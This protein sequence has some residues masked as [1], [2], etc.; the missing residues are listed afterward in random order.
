MKRL[1]AVLA[2]VGLVGMAAFGQDANAPQ[3]DNGF[4][5]N[6]LQNKLSAPGRQIN[7]SGVSGALSSQAKI[8]KIT[9]SDAQGPWFEIDNAEIDWNRLALLR[10]RVDVNRLHAEKIAWLRRPVMPPP[11]R[12]LPK[13]EAQPF[14]LP[15]LPVSINLR[16]LALDQVVFDEA[17]FGQQAALQVSG[18]LSLAGGALDST[19]AVKRLD[20]PGGELKLEASFSNDTRQLGIDIELQEPQGGV[21]ATLLNI[22]GKPAIDLRVQGSG[23]LDNV[24]VNFSL[25]AA[26]DRIAEGVVALRSTDAGLGF[27]VNFNGGLSPLIPQ[28]FRDFFAGQSTVK[29]TGVK[30]NEGGLRID[31]LKVA[32][33]ALNLTGGL[34]TGADNFLRNLT[35]NGS[36][37]DPAGP[38]VVLPVPGGQTKLQSAQLHVSFGEASRWDGLVVLDRLQSGDIE[39][40]DVTLRLGGLAQHLEDPAQRTVTVTV[41]GLAT[42]VSSTDPEVARALGSRIDLFADAALTPGGPVVVHQ[43]QVSGNGLSIFSAGQ[44][45]DLTYAG[46]NAVRVSDLAIFSGIANRPLSGSV[47]LRANGSVSPLSGG[48]DL[49]LDGGATD[50]AL[51]D[52]RLDPLLAGATTI[53]GRAVRD[54]GGIRTEDLR[55]SNPQVTF[56][57]DGQIASTKTDI[58]F[59]ATLSDLKLIDPRVSG[60]V[61]ATGH[62]AGNGQPV[63][64]TVSAAIPQGELMGRRLTDASL[65]FDGQV[66]GS[67][68]TGSLTGSGGLNGL[69]LSLAGDVAVKGESRSISGLEVMVGPNRLSGGVSKDG[70]APAVGQLTLHAPDIAPVAALALVDASGAIDADIRLDKADV[71]QG[72]KLSMNASQLVVAGNRIGALDASADIA[73]A[74]GIPLIDGELSATDLALAGFEV[75]SLH[76]KADQV[77]QTKMDFSAD[78]RL[79]IGTLAD[80]SG[81]LVRLDAGFAA[82]LDSLRLR[83]EGVAATLT[84]PATVTIRDGAV[85]LT[86]LRLDFGSG[87]LTAE[88]RMDENFDLAVAIKDLP[89][90]LANTIRPDL[91]LAGTIN[92]TAQVTGPRSSP[93]VRFDVTGTEIASGMTRGAGLPPVSLSATGSTDNGKLAVDAKVGT[94]NGLAAEA[95]GTVPLGEGDLDVNIDLQSFPLALVDRIAG[96]RGLRGT[97]SGTGHATGPLSDP[98]VTF[99]L[100]GEGVAATILAENGIPPLTLTTSGSYR[101]L[102]LQLDR[103]RISGPGGL[104]LEG[105]GRIP[106]RGAGLDARVS[107][108]VPLALADTILAQRSAQASGVLRVDAS[109]RGSLAQPQLAGTVSLAG[110][111]L[112]DPDTNVRL[113]NISLDAG[114]EGNVATL[115]SFRAEVATGGNITAQG[116]VTLTPTYPADL[117]ANLNN[118]RY[119]DGAFVTTQLNGNLEMSGPLVGGGGLLSGRIDLGKTEISIA[120]GLGASAQAALEDVQQ[121]DPSAGVKATLERARVGEPRSSEPSNRP[122]IGLDVRINAPS[123]IFVRGRGLDVELGG[124]LQLQGATNDIQPVGQFDLRRGRLLVLGQRIEFDEGSLQLVGNLDPLIHFVAKTQSGDVTAIVTVDGRVSAPEITFSSEPQLPQDEVLARVLFNRAAQ[125]LSAFQLAQLAAAAAELAGGGSGPGFLSQIR[126]ATGLDDLDIITQEDGSTAVRAGKYID[127]NIYL[128]VQTDTEG[129]SRAEVNLDVTESLTARGSVGS[130]GNTTIGLFFERDY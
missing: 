27:D 52:P 80:L 115:R 83:Q 38:P 16:E 116:R 66:N 12:N 28:Q 77:D 20:E 36:L 14:S 94:G 31:T 68:V 25:D 72:V 57:S 59:T 35:L 49:T 40:E 67:D 2:F 29:V 96:S 19:L 104:D 101:G 1:L 82:T 42:G 114:L 111:T 63:D 8:A 48:F 100:R 60:A 58:G 75:A 87:S 3:D 55:I 41:E 7:L 129:V 6:L 10:G 106:F 9:I 81:Q 51:G 23:P 69:V 47:D 95:K 43:L 130:D 39:M 37:G 118:V 65:G 64:V 125:D 113:Q 71:G 109:A 110:G 84:A 15:E 74:L 70:A 128:D 102:A 85:D 98:S 4:L 17:V 30:K 92:G 99:D 5:L 13:A 126:G 117:T 122:G 124:S 24:D 89:L 56:A 45:K 44:F 22:E 26:N 46:R 90:A 97:V 103:A 54:E 32:G 78:A 121:V 86:P 11:A 73:N 21:V 88:G 50:L 123:Q 105:S 62:A 93:D 18:A 119:T 79:A 53:S 76:A 120:E 107:G 112:V 34:E 91:G 61:T 33:A 108:A 127:D